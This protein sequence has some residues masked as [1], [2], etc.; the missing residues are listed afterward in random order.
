MTRAI[1]IGYGSIGAR[2]A[3]VLSELGF[4]IT[5]V[6]KRSD[7]HYESFSSLSRCLGVI[8]KGYFIIA[9]E[10]S[11]HLDTLRMLEPLLEQPGTK[12][13]IEKPLS[14]SFK[15]HDSFSQLAEVKVAYNLRFDPMILRIREHITGRKVLSVQVYAGQY[16][17][18]WR[19]GGSYSESYS[20]KRDLGGGVIRDLSHEL[21]YI[22]WLFG[23]WQ[24]VVAT[25]A[26][27]S[28]LAIETEDVC[29]CLIS[30]KGCH[31]ITL[32]LNYLDRNTQRTIT[33]NL[34]DDTLHCDLVNRTLTINRQKIHIPI[35]RNAT[36]AEMH[37][38]VI[39][40]E[41]LSCTYE[42]AVRIMA[43]I[44]GIEY[45]TRFQKW[46]TYEEVVHDLR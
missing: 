21:D 39:A 24:K 40:G 6:T 45:S 15:P 2:H 22:N 13:L 34:E 42:E 4:D 17:P 36:Y 35:H 20:A 32:E 33:V 38:S 7:C 26:K 46:I 11:K 14:D 28:S 30:T 43:L 3:A 23:P 31:H 18:S 16:L 37:R 5:V 25:S 9:N 8:D 10:T 1:I 12:V 29:S 27:V 41:S 44:T 19:S